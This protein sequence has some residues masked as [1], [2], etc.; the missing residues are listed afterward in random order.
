MKS[1]RIK[2]R[3]FRTLTSEMFTHLPNLL[4]VV[5]IFAFVFFF[6]ILGNYYHTKQELK[7]DG[8]KSVQMLE[9]HIVKIAQQLREIDA[10]I[11]PN[12]D[13]EDKLTLRA[14]VFHS[15]LLKE[16][17]VYHQGIVTC[18]SN[19]GS[20][21]IELG[22][23]TMQ[24]INHAA[25]NITISLGT[26]KS[27]LTTFFIYTSVNQFHGLNALIPPEK[28][29]SIIAPFLDLRQ[30]RY[31]IEIIDH[32]LS[33][34]NPQSLRYD[35]TRIFQSNLY[36]LTVKI[37]P[38]AGTYRYHYFKHIWQTILFASLVSLFYLLLRYQML[39]KRSIEYSLLNAIDSDQI[40]LY[41]QPIIDINSNKVV[42]SEAL[43]RWNHPAQ[44]KISPEIFIPLAEKLGVIDIITRKTFSTVV[45]FLKQHP[46][47]HEN[48]YISINLSR[49]SLINAEF[50]D[51]LKRFA[52]RHPEYIQSILL[53]VT[54][55]I[56][57]DQTELDLA[58]AHLDMIK[59][60]GFSLAIDD[61]GTGYSG[62]NFIRLHP[63]HVMK[64]DKV[65]IKSLHSD[66]T[67]TPVLA[68]MIHLAN[69]LK[70]KV[71]AEG[72]ETE[73]QIELLRK[74]GVCYIQGFYYSQPITPEA[75]IEYSN[76][77]SSEPECLVTA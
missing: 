42:G 76:Q 75:L 55:N 7:S 18:T 31:Q 77:S 16:V 64:I 57:F 59:V 24:R 50:I 39:A 43:V 2:T 4:P 19:E 68:S 3:Q 73:Q 21:H 71:I 44:G 46:H 20:T 65:F 60:M 14:H 8:Q 36:P 62:L 11:S 51:Y 9:R 26:S 32:L 34:D 5:A 23:D 40:E 29:L 52:R 61:F 41:L 70:M 66:S 10:Q 6:S 47:Y 35:D 69:E 49:T 56:D 63:F 45:K 17:G 74:L 72:V 54:E 1:A 58:L 38:T 25:N 12:C 22:S 27:N 67:I 48:H 15:D 13:L 37:Q 33:D 28:I 53:E 30:Y